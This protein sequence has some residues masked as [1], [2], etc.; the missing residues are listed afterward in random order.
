MPLSKYKL[1]WMLCVLAIA[2]VAI[3]VTVMVLTRNSLP[4][5]VMAHARQARNA[6]VVAIGNSLIAAG[7]DES[8][9]DSGMGVEKE[10]GSVNVGLGA[11]SPVEQ[12]LLFR[13]ARSHGMH[14]QILVYGFYD[15]QL[16][17]S[18]KFATRDFIGN[19]DMLYYVEPE[20][21]LHFYQLSPHDRA[22]FELMRHFP[23]MVDRSAIWAKVELLRRKLAQTGMPAQQVNRFGRAGDFTL[24]EARDAAEFS[25]K[26]EAGTRE[27]LITPINELIRQASEAGIKVV[28]VEMPM[29][30]SHLSVFYD[31]PA[32]N[33][34]RGHIQSL[35]VAQQVTY[36]DASAW[37][38]GEQMFAD[39]LH[40]TEVA[41]AQ[42]SKRLGNLLRESQ[43]AESQSNRDN[44]AG[45]WPIHGQ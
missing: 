32:W 44:K 39:R 1:L 31:S 7:F 41:A 16:T 24:L 42:F 2:L 14:P 18:L 37:E 19:R 23:M 45:A 33:Q 9:F 17:E 20:Y 3:N 5:R 35:L 43:I 38:A 26:C 13:Y 11:S 34:Y 22:E 12:L 25:R 4:R 27:D 40:L 10:R 15:Q 28:F 36:V 6:S 30:P 8:A 21:G 29:H